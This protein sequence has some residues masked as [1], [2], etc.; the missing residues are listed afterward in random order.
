M[1]I[2]TNIRHYDV[3][4]AH[5]SKKL[6]DRQKHGVR[7]GYRYQECEYMRISD[8]PGRFIMFMFTNQA[9]SQRA[10]THTHAQCDIDQ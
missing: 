6:I 1:H 4:G 3:I 8:K 2:A 9:G 5:D 10:D 7:N